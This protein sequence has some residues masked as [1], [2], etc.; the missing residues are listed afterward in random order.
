MLA[1]LLMACLCV[2]T[3]RADVEQ[4]KVYLIHPYTAQDKTV[5]NGNSVENDAE[6]YVE[7]I[8]AE[9]EGQKWVL[10]SFGTNRFQITSASYGKSVDCGNN[11]DIALLQWTTKTGTAANQV[12][13][14]TKVSVSDAE[15][16]YQISATAA[17]GKCYTWDTSDNKLRPVTKSSDPLTYFVF[18]ETSGR[19]FTYETP[20]DGKNYYIHPYANTY[21]AWGNGN[22]SDD[23]ELITVETYEMGNAGQQWKLVEISDG[24]FQIQSRTYAESIDCSTGS[25]SLLQWKTKDAPAE[26]QVFVFNPVSI[27]GVSGVYQISAEAYPSKCYT[28]NN[29]SNELTPVALTSADENSYFV[30]EEMP[31]SN[32]WEDE[33]IFQENKERGH[34]TF[35]PYSS[36]TNM[37]ADVNYKKAW[38]TPEK[39]DVMLLN[40]DWKFN[41]VSEPS[42]R[43]TNFY[44]ESYDVSG[45]DEIQ[46]PSNWEMKGYDVPIYCN[47]AYPHADTPP[48]IRANSSTNPGGKNYGVNPVGSYVRTFTLPQGWDSSRRVFISF[49]GIYSAAF[50]YLNGQYVGYTQGAN[51]DHEF[52][53]TPYVNYTGENR[54]A[55]QVF[56]WCDGSYYE[57]QDMFRVSGI[58]RDVFLYTTPKTYVRDHY[59]TSTLNASDNY[60]SGT[61]NVQ[62]E[63]DNRDKLAATKTVRVVLTDTLGTTIA[64]LPD[65]TFTFEAGDSTLTKSV[66]VAVSNLNLWSAEKPNL[67]NVEV[68]QYNAAG[69]L[70][71]CFTTK[72][73]FK[74][75]AISNNLLWV[76]GER[77]YLHGT[78]R[79]DVDPLLGHA[80]DVSTMLRDVTLMKQHNINTIRTSHYP[81]QAK[82]YAMFDYYG[83]YVI[84]EADVEAHAHP[85][86]STQESW[87]PMMVDR[88]ERMVLRDRN[89]PSVIIWSL[90]NESSGSGSLAYTP[91]FIACYN[92]VRELDPRPIHYENEYSGMD[93]LYSDIISR[94]YTALT[95]VDTYNNSASYLTKPFFLCE[96]AHAMGNAMGNL[97]EYWDRIYD[98]NRS[99]GGCI[100]E[101]IDHAIYDPQE[102]KAGNYEGRFHTGADFYG[103]Y[104]GVY[105][106]GQSTPSGNFCSDGLISPRR[107]SS[108]KLMEVKRV[109]QDIQ[110]SSWTQSSKQ[111]TVQ[112]RF[113]FTSTDQ[114]EMR[115]QVLCDGVSVESGTSAMPASSADEKVTVSVP[116]TTELESGHEYL[117]NVSAH[118]L[119]ATPW[120]EAG[121]EIA[122]GQ[123]TLQSRSAL[124]TPTVSAGK[125]VS[126]DESQS[127]KIVVKADG[128]TAEFN[129]TS[130]QLTA[131]T[132]GEKEILY[133]NGGPVFDQFA[134]TENFGA[135]GTAKKQVDSKVSSAATSFTY[136]LSTDKTYATITAVRKAMD[137]ALTYTMTYKVYATG[138]MDVTVSYQNSDNTLPRI[139][140]SW[141]LASDL[142][143]VEYYARGPW[144]NYCDR[145]TGA[146]LGLYQTSV[147]DMRELYVKPQSMGNREDMR[148]VILSD[149]EGKGV[150]IESNNS[151]CAFTALRFTDEQLYDTHHDY[152]LT[153]QP[154]ISLHLDYYHRGL[155]NST[156][157][158]STL[159]QYRVPTGTLT[160]SFRIS[161]ATVTPSGVADATETAA[162]SISVS[163]RVVTCHDLSAG[164]LVRLFDATGRFIEGYFAQNA[165][166]H[167]FAP[168]TAAGTYVVWMQTTHG[169][170]TTKVLVK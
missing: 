106:T 9:N 135:D 150:R 80:V 29:S 79:H 81:N 115:W 92:K 22:S 58:Y 100:W 38:L 124:S 11:A 35:T 166:T 125:Q 53:L 149:N 103:P 138:E 162:P 65:A 18:E 108:Q 46:V 101:W 83:L 75:E 62:L 114:Y 15:N 39:A 134:W 41:L 71:M 153:D 61:L 77:I 111:V 19:S 126:I 52:D 152:E 93:N 32:Y 96:Y 69:Q 16:V 84:D 142:G 156:C 20:T 48:Y 59:I 158:P 7:D 27:D 170:K 160:H 90:G 148:Y 110:F 104:Y 132:L 74:H 82:M 8:D 33:T 117:L 154:F 130:S 60:K 146:M 89:H 168:L 139:G 55:V 169:V 85:S 21:K 165:T 28:W 94:M 140:L 17:T 10:T 98:S 72:Y 54:L 63:V 99:I 4:G 128:L 151:Q 116:Y 145:K 26:N 164:S 49:G 155:G 133:S 6:L 43:P 23:D 121:Y 24:K 129:T 70:E 143:N 50:V 141:Q 14:F 1:T 45:W 86:L 5:G 102:I 120:A 37:R 109:Y 66:S 76:N 67:Y 157:G 68:S 147:D 159:T 31:K 64:T 40:G 127:G 12:F 51:N 25:T 112:N 87:E 36:A 78:N 57:C 113:R 91:N 105:Y 167:S 34:A 163:D 2:H 56:R 119:T 42:L 95:T 136:S 123:F 3:A 13:L 122:N 47:I 144:A 118:L 44:E 107:E 131:L 137:N 30:L 73:G 97:Q 161:A 88:E